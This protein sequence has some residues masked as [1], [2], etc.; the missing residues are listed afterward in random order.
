MTKVLKIFANDKLHTFQ[1]FSFVVLASEHSFQVSRVPVDGNCRR[2]VPNSKLTSKLCDLSSG[3]QEQEGS[4][5]LKLIGS[6]LRYPCL[7]PK[8][9]NDSSQ[10]VCSVSV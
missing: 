3:S 4:S 5:E 1:Y 8:G 6:M 7:F 2:A 10:T 9:Y